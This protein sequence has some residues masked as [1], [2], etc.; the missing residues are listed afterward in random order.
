MRYLTQHAAAPQA[1]EQ[2]APALASLEASRRPLHLSASFVAIENATA[3]TQ[4]WGSVR[5]KAPSCCQ[6]KGKR[7][8]KIR[9][10]TSAGVSYN[11]D[12]VRI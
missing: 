3:K 12:S 10:A 2:G 4:V 1:A 7:A 9:P 6:L 5:W 11:G 8:A